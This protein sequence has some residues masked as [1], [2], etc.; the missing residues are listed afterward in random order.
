MGGCPVAVAVEESA[1]NSAVQN[2]VEGEV[3]RLRPPLADALIPFDEA[4]DSQ[5]LVIGRAAAEAAIVRGVGVLKALSGRHAF[6]RLGCNY[7]FRPW[8]P[9][10]DRDP[11]EPA[12]TARK[13]TRRRSLV[14]SAAVRATNVPGWIDPA[15]LQ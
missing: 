5:P 10:R 4:L 12:A 9:L 11:R 1:A 15:V 3:M 6:E 8:R 13:G 14:L 2:A 7:S